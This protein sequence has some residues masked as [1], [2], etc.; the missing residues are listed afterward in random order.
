MCKGVSI[1]SSKVVSYSCMRK[2]STPEEIREIQERIA[3]PYTL[4][5]KDR[6]KAFYELKGLEFDEDIFEKI[7]MEH[8]SD[9]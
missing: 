6:L 5:G 4:T 2:P 8:C 9:I 1:M 3:D 7:I